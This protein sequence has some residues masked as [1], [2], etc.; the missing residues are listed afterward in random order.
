MLFTLALYAAIY[1]VS[2]AYVLHHLVN[3]F[4]AWLVVVH[5]A[6]L[7]R[8]RSGLEEQQ[9]GASGANPPSPPGDGHVKK[10]P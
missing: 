2:Y 5:F 8:R 7:L 10:M 1:G 4:A 3:G 9:R 6:P